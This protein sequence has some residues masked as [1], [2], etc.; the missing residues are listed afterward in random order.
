MVPE[1]YAAEEWSRDQAIRELVRSRLSALGPVDAGQLAAPLGLNRM[2]VDISLL[3]LQQEGFV[4]QGRFTPGAARGEG[5][6]EWCER[7]LLARI[8]RY[9]LKRLRREIEP[10]EPRDFMRFFWT[11]S[12]FRLKP[13]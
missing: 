9:T 6:Q 3:S 1:E 2:D 7:H 10:V 8:H 4:L 5:N 13:R 12:T 11:G